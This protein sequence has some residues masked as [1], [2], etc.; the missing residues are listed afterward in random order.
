MLRTRK[1]VI[2]ASTVVAL[3]TA[4]AGCTTAATVNTPSSAPPTPPPASSSAPTPSKS[5]QYTTSQQQ[6]ITAAEGY[7]SDGQGFSRAGLISQLDS[8]SG[9]GFSQADATFAVNHVSVNWD[10]QAAIAAKGY[11]SDG[12][13]FSYSGLVQQLE[14]SA[15]SQFTHAQAVYGAKAAGLT[16]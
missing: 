9:N 16:P 12:Q 13:G 11:V 10:Q 7:L 2:S 14:S 15:G 1:T 8:P 4:A 3:A 6:A 5:P